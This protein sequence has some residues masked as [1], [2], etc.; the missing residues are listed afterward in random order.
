MSL[1]AGCCRRS[2]QLG[3]RPVLVQ[4]HNATLGE[5]M[6]TQRKEQKEGGESGEQ[7]AKRKGRTERLEVEI[8][9]T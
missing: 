1:V 3:I 9:E 4:G 2:V 6:R 7:S 8:P 5:Y